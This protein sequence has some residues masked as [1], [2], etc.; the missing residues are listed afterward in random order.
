MLEPQ[1]EGESAK[2]SREKSLLLRYGFFTLGGSVADFIFGAV[3]VTLLLDRGAA[4][5]LVGTMLAATAVAAVVMEAPSGALGD[6]FGHRRLLIMGLL[7]WGTG[8]VGFGLADGLLVALAGMFLWAVGF[9]LHSGTLTAIVVNRIGARDRTSR[10]ARTIRFGQVAG[11]CGSALGAA[12]VLVAGAWLDAGALVAAGGG[13]LVALGLLAP[14][15]F[16]VSPKQPGRAITAIVRESVVELATRRFAPLVAL[17]MAAATVTTALV[18]VWQPLVRAE[19]GEDVRINGLYLLV[20]TVSLAAGAACSRFLDQSRPHWWGPVFAALSGVPLVLAVFHVI[21][22]MA[23]VIG[24]EFFIGLTG[25]FSGVWQ[26]LLY[27]DTNRNTMF[28]A[29][30]MVGGTAVGLTHLTTG[31]LW[32]L[33]GLGP[34]VAVMASVSAL[35]AMITVTLFRIFPEST[36]FA[37]TTR[38]NQAA[39]QPTENSENTPRKMPRKPRC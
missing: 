9:A 10:I 33:A 12:S 36:E 21:P 6:R 25:V 11:R 1:P 5:G 15:C 20:M 38:E 7:L 22:L 39:I 24:T 29:M 13:L 34:A 31:W 19:H 23:G 14:W 18:L 4:P 32:D 2:I 28:S 17:V 35:L 27:T 16:P 37:T 26:H 8:F 30:A 3:F